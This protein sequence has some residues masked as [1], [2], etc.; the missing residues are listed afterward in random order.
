VFFDYDD[1]G[2]I[3]LFLVDGGSLPIRLSRVWAERAVTSS[4]TFSRSDRH[5]PRRRRR[6]PGVG[7]SRE[8]IGSST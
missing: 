7:P 2:W 5:H 4:R 6:G 3:D 8:G 1:D